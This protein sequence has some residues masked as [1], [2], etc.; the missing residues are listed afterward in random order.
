MS[1]PTMIMGTNENDITTTCHQ[2]MVMAFSWKAGRQEVPS[3][4]D[5]FILV[6]GAVVM[7]LPCQYNGL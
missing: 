5:L 7:W 4:A 2:A 1:R 6:N 3:Q